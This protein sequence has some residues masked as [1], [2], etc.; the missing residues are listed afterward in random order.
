[1]K[2]IEEIAEL[3]NIPI[4]VKEDD[5]VEGWARKQNG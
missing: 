2:E 4:T 5:V 1:M 3:R